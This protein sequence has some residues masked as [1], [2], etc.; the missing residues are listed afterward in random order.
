MGIWKRIPGLDIK[1]LGFKV[2][3]IFIFKMVR[4]DNKTMHKKGYCKIE[5]KITLFKKLP[6]GKWLCESSNCS[7]TSPQ[8]DEVPPIPKPTYSNKFQYV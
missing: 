5:G 2:N 8:W 7:M 4:G 3:P 1:I 6:N